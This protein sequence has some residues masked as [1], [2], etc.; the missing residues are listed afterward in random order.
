MYVLPP[1]ID[2][3][4]RL[5]LSLKLASRQSID[6]RSLWVHCGTA[7]RLG[8]RIGLHRDGAL[9]GLPPFETEM[10][11]R[12]WWQIVVFD[13]RIAELSGSGTSIL[14]AMFDTRLPSN[15]NDSNL[16]PEMG[17]MPPDHT[18]TTDMT[19]VLARYEISDFLKRSNAIS[20]SF[21]NA[22]IKADG[23]PSTI[24]E[25][26]TAIDELEQQLE[27]KYLKHC[28]PQ[29][30]LHF[31]TKMFSRTAIYRMRLVAHHPR[32]YPDKGASMPTEEKDLLCRL[33]VNMIENDNI[34]HR[35]ASAHKFS[36]WIDANFQFPAF[37]Y[38]ISELRHRTRG[39]LADRGWQ[40][41]NESFGNR[42]GFIAEKKHSPMFH[43][44]SQLALK[45]WL[46]RELD[47]AAHNEP[48]PEPPEYILTLRSIFGDPSPSHKKQKIS[49]A[50]VDANYLHTPADSTNNQGD[51]SS[52]TDRSEKQPHT[53]TYNK[54]ST[55]LAANNNDNALEPGSTTTTTTDWSPMDWTYW[56]EL[57][58][59]WEPQIQ[60][61]VGSE[62]F[63]FGQP[64]QIGGMET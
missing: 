21:D 43:A 4:H 42:I 49:G 44:T 64:F 13:T 8:Q 26:D 46:A 25:K 38:L 61:I 47:A 17:D 22:W 2:A 39:E 45:A 24:A 9:L 55:A 5:T 23:A 36:W 31:L 32:H 15:V 30:T 54:D 40:A 52:S 6:P 12:L 29:I 53:N 18:G 7:I 50:A 11:R 19:F 62:Q 16:S 63:N 1:V 14:S 33:S 60:D 27:K 10:R 56:D 35:N 37:I 58:Q 20:F 34:V 48:S 51:N 28:D 57:I 3:S 59:N 41:L